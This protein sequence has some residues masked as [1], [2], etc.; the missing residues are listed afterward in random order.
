M[1][2]KLNQGLDIP[3]VQSLFHG[4]KNYTVKFEPHN[5][6]MIGGLLLVLILL[7][8]FLIFQLSGM[9]VSLKVIL[10]YSVIVFVVGYGV[11]GILAYYGISVLQDSKKVLEKKENQS[12]NTS[13]QT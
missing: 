2:K 9:A 13:Q 12:E 4:R 8:M 1:R 6:G 7:S 5:I 11:I 10:M 3:E